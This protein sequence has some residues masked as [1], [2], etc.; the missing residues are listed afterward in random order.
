MYWKYLIVGVGIV[1]LC[2][3]FAAATVSMPTLFSDHM[4]LQRGTKIPIWGWAAPGEK[5]TVALGER[6]ATAVTGKDGNWTVRLDPL[7]ASGPYTL[8]VSGSNTLTIKD[9]LIGDVWV[10]GGQSWMT[11]DM[12]RVRNGAEE[13]AA[14]NHPQIRLFLLKETTSLTPL[15]D[16]REAAWAV[17]TPKT[18]SPFSGV[19]YF[20]ACELQQVLGVPVGLI[21][22]GVSGTMAMAWTDRASLES[23]P[24]L[25]THVEKLDRR[26][27]EYGQEYYDKYG[28]AWRAWLAG[29]DQAKE[30]GKPLPLPP[31]TEPGNDPRDHWQHLSTL[32]YNG[33]VAP[34]IPYAIT[35]V[36]WWQGGGEGPDLYRVIFPAMIKSWRRNWGQGDFPFLFV[37]NAN[38]KDPDG[39]LYTRLP[40]FRE[41]QASA[42]SLANTG[43][44][45][46]ID[47]ND[48]PGDLHPTNMQP[49]G[50]RLALQ[51][52]AI[53]YHKDVVSS[54]PVYDHMVVENNKV[55]VYFKHIGGGLVALGGQDLKGF[56]VAGEDLKFVLANATIDG[57]TVVVSNDKV[58]Q[59]AAVRYAWAD[60]PECNFYNA[61]GLPAVPFRTDRP[62]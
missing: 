61:D 56:A 59:P 3:G 11:W 32:F 29:V 6:T 41:A 37:Q 10:C 47:I 45:V 1:L 52:E 40:E 55:R 5:V 53:A 17:C 26:V 24:V 27:V 34:V 33:M 58:S 54:G 13:I 57:E 2:A 23:D 28:Q 43:M 46:A 36:I 12:A 51:A 8:T 42:L 44:V 4:V 31:L 22:N 38:Y 25:K 62:K 60:N 30:L 19:G 15:R 16:C 7:P 50:K 49:V 48:N 39:P 9:V 20:F 14:A 21:E 35:G 18:V